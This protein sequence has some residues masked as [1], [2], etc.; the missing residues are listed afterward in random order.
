MNTVA[1]I[2]SG[3]FLTWA[4]QY[5]RLKTHFNSLQRLVLPMYFYL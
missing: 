5:S 4:N 3:S 2:V 1:G